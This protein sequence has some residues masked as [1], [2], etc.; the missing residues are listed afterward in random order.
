MAEETVASCI[1][2][3]WGVDVSRNVKWS[4]DVANG[5]LDVVCPR[6]GCRPGDR[7]QVDA[8]SRDSTVKG[9]S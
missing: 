1:A 5:E 3:T 6:A 7:V 9:L 2:A 4:T 8:L